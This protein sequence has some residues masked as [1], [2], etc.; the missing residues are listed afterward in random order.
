ME[1]SILSTS[2]T[3]PIDA[4]EVKAYMGYPLTD[5]SQDTTIESMITTA[6][7]WLEGRTALS[8]VSK[9]YK[10]Y[11]EEDENEDGWYELPVS[12]VLD[13]PAIVCTMNGTETTYQQRGLKTV[14][15]YPDSVFGT[16]TAGVSIPSY[17]EVVFQAG[18]TN[19][20]ANHVLLELVSIAFN[21][22]DGGN[23][24]FARLPYDLRQRIQSLSLNL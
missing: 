21:N 7:A 19:E 23:Q 9:S 10:A 16:I 22:R 12:P 8:L 15:V 17:L 4:D 24:S 14:K 1:L 2:I 18:A 20:S 13:T 3:E 6:R 11:F 5:T